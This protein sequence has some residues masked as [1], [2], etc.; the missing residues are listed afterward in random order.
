M[1]GYSRLS[2]VSTLRPRPP[3]SGQIPMCDALH[4]GRCRG[5]DRRGAQGSAGGSATAAFDHASIG[6]TH[7]TYSH[8]MPGMQ[9]AA[10]KIDAGLRAALAG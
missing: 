3:A 6:I 4:A 1:T 2:R 8:V 7:D 10:T 9:E 5:E